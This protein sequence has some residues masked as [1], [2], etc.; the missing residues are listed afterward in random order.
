LAIAAAC[1]CARPCAAQQQPAAPQT[2]EVDISALAPEELRIV[3]WRATPVWVLRRSPAMLQQ[4]ASSALLAR[5]ADPGPD[6]DRS[7]RQDI[8]VGIARCPHAGCVPV[9]RLKAGPRPDDPENWPGGFACPCHFAT[10]DLAG[11]VFKDKPTRENIEVPP[12]SYLSD[13]RVL[14]GSKA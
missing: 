12:H 13:T 4:L 14:I 3:Q 9:A 6:N 2:V 5:L 7:L 1:L 8:F 10:F 11:R